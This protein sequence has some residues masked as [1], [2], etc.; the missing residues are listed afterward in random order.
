MNTWS[1]I[2]PTLW[3]SPRIKQLLY[4]LDKS[5]FINEIILIDNNPKDKPSWYNSKD[6]NKL[7]YLP[8]SEN[9]YVNP[10]WN[11]GVSIAKNENIAISNDDIEWM[12]AEIFNDTIVSG[13]W[14]S[15]GMHRDNWNAVSSNSLVDLTPGAGWGCLILVKKSKWE[16]IPD[17]LKIWLGDR[18]I[19]AYNKNLTFHKPGFI[20][21]EISVTVGV[22]GSQTIDE[23][24]SPYS[25]VLH[26]DISNWLT[27][28]KTDELMA[29]IQ[30]NIEISK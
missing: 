20:K 14:T 27:Y 3:K 19:L 28:Y 5:D 30:K 16:P 18:W 13:D 6:F 23:S 25:A 2:I 17:N 21:G 24:Q 15:I 9:I 7:V 1:V 12:P 22:S 11:L 26:E 4:N 29:R 8:M 10:A